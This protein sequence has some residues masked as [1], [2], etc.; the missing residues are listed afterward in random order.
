[1]KF[2]ILPKLG[3]IIRSKRFLPIFLITL[4]VL[5][6]VAV[7]AAAFYFYHQYQEVNRD[8]L[9]A[10]NDISSFLKVA[11]KSV[12]LPDEEPVVATVS[13]KTKLQEQ[14]FFKAAENGD[15]VFIYAKNELAVLFRPSINKIIQ[16]MPIQAGAQATPSPT[17]PAPVRVA[18]YNCTTI[19]G[20]SKSS[21]D[22]ITTALPTATVTQKI[23]AKRTDY[24]KTIV[25]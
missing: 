11:A 18:L 8:K 14:A 10:Q 19:P 7:S 2:A 15:K 16:V 23:S 5:A 6:F 21:Q 20:L 12:L 13:D 17:A 25:V 9:A 1:M 22:K 24:Q 3:S 4:V